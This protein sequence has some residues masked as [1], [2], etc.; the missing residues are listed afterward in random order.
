MSRKRRKSDSSIGDILHEK[1][2]VK[3]SYV[4]GDCKDNP[5]DVHGEAVARTQEGLSIKIFPEHFF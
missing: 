1:S 4:G 2:D 3:T 5:G